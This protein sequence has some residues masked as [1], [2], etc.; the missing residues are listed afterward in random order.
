MSAKGRKR[1]VRNGW[2]VDMTLAGRW[3]EETSAAVNL[4]GTRRVLNQDDVSE[5]AVVKDEHHLKAVP[6]V[7]KPFP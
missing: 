4:V 7:G 6:V 2:K 5:P 1:N 3:F